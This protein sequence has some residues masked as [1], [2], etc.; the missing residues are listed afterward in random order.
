MP[1]Y[2]IVNLNLYNYNSLG[3][4]FLHLPKF[5]H[6]YD[7]TLLAGPCWVLGGP[8]VAAPSHPPLLFFPSPSLFL[9]LLCFLLLLYL[10]FLCSNLSHI[11]DVLGQPHLQQNTLRSLWCLKVVQCL[12]SYNWLGLTLPVAMPANRGNSSPRSLCLGY[13]GQVFCTQL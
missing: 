10:L 11:H 9:L 1:V 2:I 8:Q 12:Y 7:N 6:F 13:T 4:T 5:F 3:L